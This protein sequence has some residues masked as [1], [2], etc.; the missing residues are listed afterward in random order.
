MI[1]ADRL[2]KSQLK[3][4]IDAALE[5]TA[6]FLEGVHYAIILKDFARQWRKWAARPALTERPHGADMS[7]L[8]CKHEGLAVD[9][10]VPVDWTDTFVVV[11]V[12]DWKKISQQFVYDAFEC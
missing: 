6:V 2:Q 8:M 1:A 4:I 10:N 9:L 5:E 12:E 7:A 3:H 11:K